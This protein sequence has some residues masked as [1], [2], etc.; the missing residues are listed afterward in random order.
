[1]AIGWAITTN[2]TEA[3]Q[4]FAG[5]QIL[6]QYFH[7]SPQRVLNYLSIWLG[8]WE[9]DSH[10][11]SSKRAIKIFLY[12]KVFTNSTLNAASSAEESNCFSSVLYEPFWSNN[13]FAMF[14]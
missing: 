4:K 1:L 12:K 7:C 13:L 11:S 6:A 3:Q 9:N 14:K 10:D 8:E 2:T 5:E